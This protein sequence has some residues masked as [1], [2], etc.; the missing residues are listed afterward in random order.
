[1]WIER[2]GLFQ[3]PDRFT[4]LTKGGLGHAAFEMQSPGP[5]KAGRKL[6]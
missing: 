4:D 3:A 1:M 2:K 6:P 5:G